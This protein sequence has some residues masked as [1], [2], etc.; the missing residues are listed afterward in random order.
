MPAGDQSIDD[1]SS[2][3]VF[4]AGFVPQRGI[5][6][7]N[8]TNHVS[9]VFGST[10]TL[11]FFGE[12]VEC[13]G[14]T[15]PRHG[16]AHAYV[17]GRLVAEI[18][19]YSTKSYYQQR[20]LHIDDL[21]PI[22]HTLHINFTGGGNVTHSGA[23]LSIDAFVVPS[24]SSLV[25]TRGFSHRLAS[26]TWSFIQKGTTGVAAMQLAIVSDKHALIIDKVEHNPLTVAGHPTWGALYDLEAHTVRPL[27][28]LSNSFCAGGSWL[29]NGTL[30]NVGGNPI[31]VD[32]TGAADFR[33][34]NGLQSVR[35]YDP[36]DDG[37]CDFQEYPA[38]MR[39]ASPRWY[40]SVTRLEDG[41]VMIIGGSFRGGWM[42]NQ[43]SVSN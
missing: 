20:I 29:S 43:T 19:A 17:D 30:L 22:Y 38:H 1:S 11:R 36:C 42:N 8:G 39:M 18:D 41:S 15:S 32:K 9:Q 31:V 14:Q 27:N 7:V 33:D 13:F 6:F 35:L 24:R 10:V 4:S 34:A 3:V 12:R 26:A 25:R 2:L 5:H 21:E 16:Q 40:N 23:F 37:Q 28:L